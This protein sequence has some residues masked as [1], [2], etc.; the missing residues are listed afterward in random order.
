M[1]KNVTNFG[2]EESLE[3]QFLESTGGMV[4]PPGTTSLWAM[5]LPEEWDSA[6]NY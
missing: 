6:M 1:H 5:N 2:G 3:L 4:I